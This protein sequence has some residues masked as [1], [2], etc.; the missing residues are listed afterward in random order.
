VIAVTAPAI[1]GRATEAGRRA[2]AE[3]LEIRPS[4]VALRAG[5]ASRDKL[6]HVDGPAQALDARL[7]RLRDGS[8]R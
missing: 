2:L 5:A 6:Y 3:A 8:A 4:A 7:R 1:D